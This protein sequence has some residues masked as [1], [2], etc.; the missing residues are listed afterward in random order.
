MSETYS[1]CGIV[2]TMQV[3]TAARIII[4]MRACKTISLKIFI[5]EVQMM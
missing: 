1:E 4:I 2:V 3:T 5:Y